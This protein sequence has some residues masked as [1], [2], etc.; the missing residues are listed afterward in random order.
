MLL[1]YLPSTWMVQRQQVNS[2]HR[3]LHVARVMNKVDYDSPW[4]ALV[5]QLYSGIVEQ[6]KAKI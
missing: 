6:T 1:V 3:Q 5:A 2:L 4:D